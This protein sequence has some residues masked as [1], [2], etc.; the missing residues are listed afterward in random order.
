MDI[1]LLLLFFSALTRS[2]LAFPNRAGSCLGGEAAVNGS[3]ISRTIIYRGAL[4]EG[5]VYT[6]IN[7]TV[8]APSISEVFYTGRDYVISVNGT[9]HDF[10]GV[11]IRL[12]INGTADVDTS[13][14]LL[15]LSNTQ[16]AIACTD[17]RIRG[18]THYN[19][20]WKASASGILRV[21]EPAVVML[22]ITVVGLN[23]AT[24]SV[25]GY[26]RYLLNFTE[27]NHL[28]VTATNTTSDDLHENPPEILTIS[29]GMSTDSSDAESSDS[30]KPENAAID[31][32]PTILINPLNTG[33]ANG[34]DAQ[35]EE[36]AEENRQPPP[37]Q[38]Y[39]G[40]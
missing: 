35:D 26:T 37:P 3:H 8:L 20:S 39:F 27:E 6:D 15:P 25:Y 2:A 11:L 38:I 23:N 19:S 1:V 29:N 14:A 36:E 7:R 30:S 34:E 4:E 28:P 10:K 16:N 21:D 24:A 22:D 9:L 31:L 5:G 32:T 40:N 18:I 17:P 33:S 13:Q 12:E